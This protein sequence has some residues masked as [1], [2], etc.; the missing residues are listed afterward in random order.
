MI[1]V[2]AVVKFRNTPTW[3]NDEEYSFAGLTKP[4][5]QILNP[6]QIEPS[7]NRQPKLKSFEDDDASNQG[8]NSAPR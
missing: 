8:M 3:K 2:D 5:L 7:R 1:R 4:L 6:Y